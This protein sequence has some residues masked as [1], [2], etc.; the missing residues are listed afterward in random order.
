MSSSRAQLDR[1]SSQ[2]QTPETIEDARRLLETRKTDA[3]IELLTNPAN[4]W[5]KVKIS[6]LLGLAYHQKRDYLHAVE[7]LSSAIKEMPE[8][9]GDYRQAIQLLGISH[10]LLSHH[11]EAIPY[12]EKASILI[13]YSAE[14]TY[15]LGTCYIQTRNPDKSRDAFARM[16][17]VQ[18]SSAAAYER[19][20]QI[21][22]AAYSIDAH[23]RPTLSS[24]S[25]PAE[26]ISYF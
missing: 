10:Y 7:Y 1:S 4:A 22:L 26:I 5:N 15:A 6:Y 2:R 18:Q 24:S 3:A 17:K 19:C 11:R 9:D 25:L 13:P 16:F 14:I 23:L 12:L 21:V 8:T 20:N